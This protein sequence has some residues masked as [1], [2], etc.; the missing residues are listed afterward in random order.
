M[1][2][3]FKLPNPQEKAEYGAVLIIQYKL[4]SWGLM[5]VAS[6]NWRKIPKVDSS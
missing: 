5:Q 4:D 6:P 1:R 3:K 2:T